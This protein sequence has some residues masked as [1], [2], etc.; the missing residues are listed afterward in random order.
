MSDDMNFPADEMLAT[1][2]WLASHLNDPTVR[3]VDT[4]KGE[5]YAQSH[6]PGAVAHG[7][8]VFLR[9]EGD[10]IGAEAF[11]ALMSGLG[12][13]EDTMIIAYDDGNS[14]F[15]CRLWWVL[16]Y[17]G[18][19][20]VKVLDGGWDLWSAEGQPVDD[21]P[22]APRE[23]RFEPRRNEAWIA[24]SAYVQGSIGDPARLILDVRGNEEW[25][26][27]EATGTTPSGHIPGA[28]HLVWSDVIEPGSK[29]FKSA[30]V[31][32]RMFENAGASSDKEI[33]A[34][35]LGGI[36]AAH[37]VLALKLAGYGKVR[38][39]EGSWAAWS[40]ANLPAEPYAA[41]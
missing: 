16:N 25:T 12:I 38:N 1:T 27:V 2:G 21:T 9:D 4:R 20:R 30:P 32:R 28:A 26:R 8:G 5:A 36:R 24:D 29:R 23:A 10:V 35:C 17:Y 18:H 31:L 41:A 14:L 40:R 15:A 13:A 6:I 37:S 39:Y 22:V 11:T 34:Y 33:I 7:G 3:I 19:T